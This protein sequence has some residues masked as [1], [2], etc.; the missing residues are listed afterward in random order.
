[1]VVV[2]ATAWEVLGVTKGTT[3]AMQQPLGEGGEEGMGG[4]LMQL[5]MPVRGETDPRLGLRA[6]MVAE[7]E[8]EGTEVTSRRADMEALAGMEEEGG[9]AG[10]EV[11]VLETFSLDFSYA[12][13][14]SYLPLPINISNTYRLWW[15]RRRRLWRRRRRRRRRRPLPGQS[16]NQ[17]FYSV[18]IIMDKSPACQILTTS[19]ALLSYDYREEEDTEAEEMTEEEAEV[20]KTEVIGRIE[21]PH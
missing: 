7:E 20:E 17:S 11:E 16:I 21:A 6:M 10:E 9:T 18:F 15:P 4:I 19:S 3:K 8:E 13:W 5:Q 12:L 1:V 2:E 14:I